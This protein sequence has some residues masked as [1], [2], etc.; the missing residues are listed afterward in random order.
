MFEDM[1]HFKSG[2]PPIAWVDD[3]AIPVTATTPRELVPLLEEVAG[4][5]HEVFQRHGMTLKCGKD[6]SCPDVSWAR[7][8]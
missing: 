1:R 5:A 7:S 6:G 3:L 2:F 8:E 4:C